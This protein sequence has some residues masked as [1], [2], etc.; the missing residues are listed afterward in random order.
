MRHK[1]SMKNIPENNHKFNS[2]D[3]IGVITFCIPKR[4]AAS[5]VLYTGGGCVARQVCH[6][7]CLPQT[8]AFAL[9]PGEALTVLL[10]HVRFLNSVALSLACSFPRGE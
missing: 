4:R 8:Q 6:P 1:S 5:S 3:P 9:S 7:D 10:T 2:L